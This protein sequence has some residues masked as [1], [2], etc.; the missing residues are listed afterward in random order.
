MDKWEECQEMVKEVFGE[1]PETPRE[2]VEIMIAMADMALG[3]SDKPKQS[4]L[5]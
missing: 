3:Y 2:L 5:S 4:I 1:K